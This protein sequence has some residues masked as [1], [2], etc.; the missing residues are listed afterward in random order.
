MS[1]SLVN[2]IRLNICKTYTENV[3]QNT[4]TGNVKF[5]APAAALIRPGRLRRR[6]SRLFLAVL[7]M[8][9]ADK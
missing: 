6:S 5:T 4:I 9:R 8:T 2:I 1:I 7:S 3:A